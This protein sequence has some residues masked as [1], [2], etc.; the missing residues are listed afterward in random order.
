ML[1]SGSP[2]LFSMASLTWRRGLEKLPVSYAGQK[3]HQKK[4]ESLQPARP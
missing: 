3:Q 1:Q 2:A 4:I